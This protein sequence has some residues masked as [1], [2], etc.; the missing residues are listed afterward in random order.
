M[1]DIDPLALIYKELP[2][3]GPGSESTTEMLFKLIKHPE[4]IKYAIDMGCGPGQSTIWLAQHGI[5]VVAIDIHQ[6]FLEELREAASKAGVTARLDIQNMSIGAVS[7]PDNS[8]DLVWSEGTAYFIGWKQA[9]TTWRRLLK[10][11]GYLIVTDLF[12]TT[13]SPSPE[14]AAFFKD[15]NVLTFE[16]GLQV[17]QESGYIVNATYI[18]PNSDWFDEYYSALQQRIEELVQHPVAAVREATVRIKQEI[19]MRRKYKTEYEHI[20]LVLSKR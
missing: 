10:S 5:N 6:P 3:Q 13:D 15:D 11:G 12:W 2:R 17:A 8:F 20:G 7:Y 4:K 9:L 16:Q 18:Q 1:N 14:P 19:D